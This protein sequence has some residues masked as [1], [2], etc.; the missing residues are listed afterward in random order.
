MKG[1]Q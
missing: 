1:Q